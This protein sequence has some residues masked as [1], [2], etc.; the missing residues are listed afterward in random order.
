VVEAETFRVVQ[1]DWRVGKWGENYFCAGWANT[2]LSR[3]AFLGAPEQGEVSVAVAEVNIPQAGR[4]H[5]LVRY[6][7]PYGYSAEFGVRL[8][9]GGRTVFER[10]YGRREN[11]KVWPFGR[12][13]QAMVW[14]PWGGGDNIVWEGVEAQV[15]LRAGP[16]RLMLT[17]GPQPEPAAR[18]NL[19]LVLLTS[20]S[21]D[22]EERLKKER[23]LPFDG[24]LT[25]RGDLFL[26][27]T[28]TDREPVLVKL[29]VTEHCPYWV[30]LRR[31]PRRSPLGRDGVCSQDRPPK[32]EWLPPGA[33][34][35]WVEIGSRLDSLNE[36]T[37]RLTTL[38]PPESVSSGCRLR[39][40]W[41]TPT[42]GNELRVSKVVQIEQP[43]DP[44]AVFAVPGNVRL[45]GEIL[46]RE[47]VLERLLA[48]VRSLPRRGRVPTKI[49]VWGFL[50]GT[51][52]GMRQPGRLPGRAG[53]LALDLALALGAN[54]LNDEPGAN[55]PD[56]VQTRRLPRRRTTLVRRS[57]TPEQLRQWAEQLR[58]EGRIDYVRAVKLGDEISLPGLQKSP[59]TDA[60]FR[61]WLQAQ[62]LTP[63]DVG[64]TD[65][66]TV[67]LEFEGREANPRLWWYSHQ[68]RIERGIAALQAQTKAIEAAFPPGVLVGANYSPHPYYWP[69]EETY[70]RVFKRGAMTLPWLEDYVWGIPELSVQVVGYITD[71][72]RCGAKYH[73]LPI[74]WYIMP[75]SPPNTPGDFRR[76][77]FTALG[78]GAKLFNLYCVDPI[79]LA[80]T[81][82]YVRHQDLAMWRAIYEVLHELG[83]VEEVVYPARLRPARVALLISGTT[84]LWDETPAYNQERKCLYYALRQGQIAVDFLSE[85]DCVEGWLDRYRVLY[86]CAD[87]LR[88][89]AARAI[90][91]WVRRGGTLFS[92]AGG[93]LE[94]EFGAPNPGLAEVYGVVEQSLEKRNTLLMTKQH[95]PRLSPLDT[96]TFRFPGERRTRTFPALA[97][98]QRLRL[99]S[100]R[101]PADASP[102]PSVWGTFADGSPAVV[103]NRYGR[104]TALLVATFPGA[105][106]VRPAIPLRPWDR[107]PS[108]GA[109]CHFLPT[110][111]D[112]AVHRLLLYPVGLA[113]VQGDVVTS[114][115]LVEACLLEGKAGTAVV[116]VNYRPRPCPRLRVTIRQPRPFHR[117]ESARQGRLAYVRGEETVTVTLPL[118]VTDVVLLRPG[119][120]K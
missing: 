117:V 72:L 7:L 25:Q 11:P 29:E 54:T 6:E 4:Y 70:V 52:S 63:G 42:K 1:G 88:S 24:L 108:P 90:C 32:E 30:H 36:N 101:G 34:T 104:G 16:A 18:R 15:E 94:N 106:Y 111:F 74:K 5:V 44:T 112:R 55:R 59:Q 71:A 79:V 13:Q 102:P 9:Q 47:E 73:D 2:F 99:A 107:S 27:L 14:Y 114:D 53:E 33:S 100:A 43:D 96:V 38:H 69:R 91:T 48:F 113:G 119:G 62:G 118:E 17:K 3:Q 50:S 31:W 78:H 84:D 81:E 10:F 110:D 85:D 51:S 87:H 76:S 49:P 45:G 67:E 22:L 23:Y 120:G 80:Y 109:M 92:V 58:R 12:G 28:N 39:V 86:L 64:A 68:F 105:A 40:E 89:D 60:A 35:P 65:W 41:G 93:G 57:G 95:L 116:L 66:S 115:P 8:E 83:A 21:A 26:R 98:R 97:F 75:H 19:D 77:F 46:T 56:L 103:F 82:N 20:D 61:N 37:L